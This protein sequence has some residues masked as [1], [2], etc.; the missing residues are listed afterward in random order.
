MADG[1]FRVLF[2]LHAACGAIRRYS[3]CLYFNCGLGVPDG[4]GGRN[5]IAKRPRSRC[6]SGS[7]RGFGVVVPA[8]GARRACEK[9][10]ASR[11]SPA[12]PATLK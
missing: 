12:G 9:A 5:K 11:V 8:A 2:L 4:G 1:V 3:W 6:A 10:V 7:A